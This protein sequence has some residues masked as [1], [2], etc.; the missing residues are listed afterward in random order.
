MEKAI[1]AGKHR[2]QTL[3]DE[4]GTMR[5]DIHTVSSQLEELNACH[6]A[7]AELDRAIADTEAEISKVG[8]E[9]ES[10]KAR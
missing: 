4:I 5:T 2:E 9:T 8:A 7:K 6:G 1:S 10:H 3:I